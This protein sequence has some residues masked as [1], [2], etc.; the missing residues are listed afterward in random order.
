[1][2]A[3]V[4]YAVCDPADVPDLRGSWVSSGLALSPARLRAR[5]VDSRW[6]TRWVT[7]TAAGDTV[8]VLPLYR[9]TGQRTADPIFDPRHVMPD[10][11]D[12]WPEDARALLFVGGLTDLIAGPTLVEL[13]SGVQE[14]VRYGL[15]MAG[16][17]FAREHG[18][19]AVALYVRDDDHA[20]FAAAGTRTTVLNW[21][22]VLDLPG[23]TWADLL[24]TVNTAR[25]YRLRAELADLDAR[26]LRA[27]PADPAEVIAEAA[28]LI[29]VIK[30][31]YGVADH[32]RLI[33]L[34]MRD[35]SDAVADEY[36]AFTLRDHRGALVGVSF[37]ARIGSVVELGELGLE[38]ELADRHLSYV[39]LMFY[40]PARF[41]MD[42]G[43]RQLRLGLDSM[44]PKTYRG[45]RAVPVWGIVDAGGGP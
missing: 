14:E 9:L 15:V 32:P 42:R 25:R 19:L 1:M 7:A 39:E 13:E 43:C 22:A 26:G 18:L 3:T 23:P 2:S 30:R 38:A 35:W 5:A 4:R 29:A 27:V 41:A 33:Q 34:R 40:A 17:G 37:V 31:K 11:I 8:G 44:A 28:P 45:A 6:T 16:L 12:D 36:R 10:L 24:A 20:A 21:S